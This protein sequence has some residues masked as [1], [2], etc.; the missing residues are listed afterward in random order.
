MEA[1]I[2][3]LFLAAVA[4]CSMGQIER[5]TLLPTSTCTVMVCAVTPQCGPVVDGKQICQPTDSYTLRQDC[6]R[7]TQDKIVE[8]VDP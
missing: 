2:R 7:C 8:C 6:N 4:A 3:F 5:T 1:M